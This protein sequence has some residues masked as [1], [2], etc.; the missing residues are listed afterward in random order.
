MGSRNGDVT[1]SGGTLAA[2]AGA[3]AAGIGGGAKGASGSLTVSG[4][5]VVA[6]GRGYGAGVGGGMGQAGGT[7]TVSGG[8][9]TAINSSAD[10]MMCLANGAGIGGGAGGKGGAVTISGG[11]VTAEGGS[12]GAGIGGGGSYYNA[13]GAD[14]GTVTISGGRVSATGGSDAAGIGGGGG[15]RMGFGA[16]GGAS[17]TVEI[18]GGTVFAAGGTSFMIGG[19]AGADI[20]PGRDGADSGANTFTGGS[21]RLANDA[22]APAPSNGAARVWCVTVTNLVPNAAV[23][24]A[25]PAESLPATFGVNDL[26]ADA[27]GKLYL[28]LPNGLYAF[29]ADG[30]GYEATVANAPTTATQGSSGGPAAPVFAADGTGFAF[31]GASF[32]IKIANA[33]SGIWYTLYATTALGGDWE[34]V[35]SVCAE[36]DGDLVFANLDATAPARFFKVEASATQP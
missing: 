6:T 16:T 18:S 4:G 28:W 15:S 27:A 10:G 31:D 3:S 22:I 2:T 35:E 5:T 19:G 13:P 21:I 32:S 12:S 33:Q 24:I 26:V 8:E 30:A 20:G 36:N 23:E 25:L 1:V 14:G 9:L 17:G 34:I 11:S 29:T 7:V